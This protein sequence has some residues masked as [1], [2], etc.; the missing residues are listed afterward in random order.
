MNNKAVIIAPYWLDPEHVGM[1]RAQRFFNWLLSEKYEIIVISVGEGKATREYEWGKE[2]SLPDPLKIYRKK[3]SSEGKTIPVRRENK[4]RRFLAYLFLIPDPLI[5]W[6]LKAVKDSTILETIKDAGLIISSSP[7][8]ASHLLAY[9][10]SKKK[11]TKLIVDLRDG[12]LDE[13]LKDV[14]RFP[15]RG[16]LEKIMER[17]ILLKSDRIFVTSEKWKKLLTT[18]IKIIENKVTVLTNGYP[19]ASGREEKIPNSGNADRILLMHSGR[20]KAGRR[21]HD[22]RLLIEPLYFFL[23][24]SSSSG[25]ILLLGDLTQEEINEIEIWKSKFDEFNWD[26]SFQKSVERSEMLKLLQNAD[27]LLLLSASEAPLPSKIFEYI[28]S[29]KPILAFTSRGS[30]VWEL[31]EQIP[32]MSVVD[33]NNFDDNIG[34]EAWELYFQRIKTKNYD[35]K[36]PDEYSE[37]SL[38]SKFLNNI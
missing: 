21:T 24:R 35:C 38:K 7:P 23:G 26:L 11:N 18:R 10:L 3:V 36:V 2:V 31:A 13:P 8:E 5:F 28:P 22:I 14:L 37:S 4:Y 9:K 32:Q 33:M 29:R 17:K 12:W 19:P 27:G 25:R 16:V 15:L 1:Y 34:K 30:A 20:F 6:V